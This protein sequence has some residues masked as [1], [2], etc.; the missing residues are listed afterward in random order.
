LM[1]AGG[2][3]NGPVPLMPDGSCPVEYPVK[4]DGA[5]YPPLLVGSWSSRLR[6]VETLQTVSRKRV[7]R[8]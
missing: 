3:A 7:L 8:K 5:C 1:N 6:P 4:Q 2:P